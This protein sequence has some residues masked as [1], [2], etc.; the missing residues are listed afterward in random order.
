VA[1]AFPSFGLLTIKHTAKHMKNTHTPGPWLRTK[2][3]N[4]FQIVA[5]ADG[6]GDPNELVATVHPAAITIDHE[7][8]DETKANARLISAAPDMLSALEALASR[9]SENADGRELYGDW[10]AIAEEA[11]NKAKGGSK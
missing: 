3:G 6:N 8:C 11:I 7:P 1:H 10:I 2:S 5:G 4:T 9:M